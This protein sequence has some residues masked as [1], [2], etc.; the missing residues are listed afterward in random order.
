MSTSLR[1]KIEWQEHASKVF[2]L[3]TRRPVLKFTGA[4]I[5]VLLS[6]ITKSKLDIA[7]I[8][9]LWSMICLKDATEKELVRSTAGRLSLLNE[10]YGLKIGAEYAEKAVRMLRD[11]QVLKQLHGSRRLYIPYTVDDISID[12]ISEENFWLFLCQRMKPYLRLNNG[13]E[14]TIF[15]DG[16]AIAYA[17]LR[18]QGDTV[19]SGARELSGF[20][21]PMLWQPLRRFG[22]QFRMKKRHTVYI[23]DI[24]YSPAGVC[25]ECL[26]GRI[27]DVKSWDLAVALHKLQSS[28]VSRTELALIRSEKCK[29]REVREAEKRYI[30]AQKNDIIKLA[31]NLLQPSTELGPVKISDIEDMP[32]EPY[33]GPR[34][35]IRYPDMALIRYPSS[36]EKFFCE[37][38]GSYALTRLSLSDEINIEAARS[39]LLGISWAL[40]ELLTYHI[41]VKEAVKL[42]IELLEDSGTLNP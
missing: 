40:S 27:R 15:V 26:Q 8:E 20:I 9:C 41:P 7:C 4:E 39:L 28:K 24:G 12:V 22:T 30:K 38:S 13:T 35:L 3:F 21:A 19:L 5:G 37:L 11:L 25:N 33:I 10:N 17:C 6:Y 1:T 23:E 29:H 32:Y 14:S 34:E 18:G 42:I 31:K 16:V 36:G 2:S